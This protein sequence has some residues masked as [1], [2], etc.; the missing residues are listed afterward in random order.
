MQLNQE[1]ASLVIF[2]IFSTA[3]FCGTLA[4]IIGIVHGPLS[5]PAAFAIGI[6]GYATFKILF[7]KHVEYI[8]W[9]IKIFIELNLKNNSD[10]NNQ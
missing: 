8:Y 10:K 6:L 1:P 9:W 5:I 3:I 4:T 2:K 7:Q